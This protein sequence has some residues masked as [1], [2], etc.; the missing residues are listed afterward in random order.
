MSRHNKKTNHK[1]EQDI[2]SFEKFKED[3]ASL[4]CS[5]CDQEFD[6]DDLAVCSCCKTPVH[7]YCLID[8]LHC[9][10]NC[11]YKGMS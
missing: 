6:D 5:S 3:I 4:K 7:S 9:C 8:Q 1:N 11:Y 2:A 10:T